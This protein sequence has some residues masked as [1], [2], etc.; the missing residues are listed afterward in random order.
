MFTSYTSI[1]SGYLNKG[2]AVRN[3]YKSGSVRLKAP[4]VVL[5]SKNRRFI[6]PK[7][8]PEFKVEQTRRRKGGYGMNLVSPRGER[9]SEY[10]SALTDPSVGLVFGIGPAGCGKT[11]FACSA[12]ISALRSGSV[13][14]IVIT[15]PSVLVEENIGF[16]P[17][18]ILKKMNP[19]LLPLFDVFLEHY[20]KRELDNLITS[21]VIEVA[22]VGFMRGRTFKSCFIIADEMQNSTPNQMLMLLTRVGEGSKIVVT[23]DLGQSD[24]IAMGADKNGLQDVLDRLY[25]PTGCGCGNEIRI[26]ELTSADVARSSLVKHVLG[27]YHQEPTVPWSNL[28][29]KKTPP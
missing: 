15:R 2:G 9:Q 6:E 24:L 14:K 18:D 20:T 26:V 27:L 21:G 29:L 25:D 3:L 28:P 11:M 17:G 4:M 1:I 12:A 13:S 7:Q 23:G 5:A 8:I 10:L 19:I 16:L 22:P